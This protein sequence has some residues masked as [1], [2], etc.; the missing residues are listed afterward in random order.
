MN[1]IS[2]EPYFY[3]S[4]SLITYVIIILVIKSNYI[5]EIP[6]T[7]SMHKERT[8]SS[9]GIVFIIGYILTVYFYQSQ[10]FLPLILLGLTGL[11]D[12]K[13][14]LSISVRLLIQIV[15][16]LWI[17][18]LI[19]L[20][21]QVSYLDLFVLVILSLFI[22]NSFNFM[23][24]IDGLSGF[25]IIFMLL[26]CIFAS[27]NQIV[28]FE[29]LNK[30][31]IDEFNI[32]LIAMT[33]IF[34]FFN[35]SSTMKLFMGN[36]GSYFIGFYLSII[37]SI[38]YLNNMALI[39][40][41]LYSV[42]LADTTYTFFTR[43]KSNIMKSSSKFHINDIFRTLRVTM[44]PH[45]AHN[46]QKLAEKHASHM[47]ATQYIQIYNFTICLPLAYLGSL[48]NELAPILIILSCSPYIYWCYYN[49][50]GL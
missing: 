39:F 28:D 45:K 18:Q 30:Y 32:S 33:I 12:D 19:T 17:L 40:F 24:G 9:G 26:C 20:N 48:F 35:L 34:L 14:N 43:F 37:M 25:Q 36:T 6:S 2:F 44:V 3:L 11:F 31:L 4:L 27:L 42:Y 15:L 5:Y 49:K 10:I 8:P 47:K 7:R 16:I 1:D 46:Y 13:F 22:I 23:D 41:I 21:Y 50:A 29:I 38:F